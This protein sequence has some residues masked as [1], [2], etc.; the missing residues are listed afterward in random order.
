MDLL[1]TLVRLAGAKP[2]SDR[3][4]D[5]E[6]IWPLMSG[7]RG[8]KSPHEMFCYYFKSQL[9]AVR[10]GKWKL[11]LPLKAKQHGW[12]GVPFEFSGAL[13]DL[14]ADI[15]EKHNVIEQYPDVV[16]RLTGLAEK[17]R[18]NIGDWHQPGKGC[19]PAGM[20]DD[21]KPLRLSVE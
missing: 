2:P 15:G 17:A 9:H 18:V 4:I 11:H 10:S 16:R 21:P 7:R 1:P 6:D 8:A 3:V 14:E 12:Q 19:R 20:V 5:G 13:Y